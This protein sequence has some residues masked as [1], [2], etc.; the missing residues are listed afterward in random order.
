MKRPTRPELARFGKRGDRVRVVL[1][2]GEERYVV[3]Y[4]DS[5]GAPHRKKFPLDADGKRE[6]IAWAETFFAERDRLAKEAAR[7]KAITIAELWAAYCESPAFGDLRPKSQ[8]S[9]TERWARW[10][11]FITSE[12]IANDTTLNDIDRFITRARV[13]IAINQVRQVLNTARIVYN[14]G[15]SRKLLTTNEF[16][17]HRW[18]RP[19][20]A[21]VLEPEEYS[22]EEFRRMLL[23]MTPQNAR[24]WRL[25]VALMLAGHQ[26]QRANAVLNLPWSAIDFTAGLIRW[27]AAFQKNG[28]EFEQPLTDE[29]R[30]ALF[31]ALYWLAVPTGKAFTR[32]NR[33]QRLVADALSRSPWVLPGHG[34]P[35]KPYGYQALW[36]SLCAIEKEAGVEHKERR[37]LHGLRKMV[38]GNV[39]DATGDDRLAMEWIGDKDQ[40]QARAYLKKRRQRME[41][42]AESISSRNRPAE[43][44][45]PE[46]EEAKS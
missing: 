7:P 26:G 9:Y 33:H 44:K 6:A 3:I 31:T 4:R 23:A 16:A 10:E 30:S 17:L 32:M 15:Q 1:D 19:K 37:A 25:H 22:A 21:K 27:P 34:D 39:L 14:W 41:R 24:R 43:R 42:A 28:T 20:D 11:R 40:K 18:K 45:P 5:D 46:P 35:S 36:K 13:L 8:V 38:A 29:G 12:A 2:R